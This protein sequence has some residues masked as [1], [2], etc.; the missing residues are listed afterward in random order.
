LVIVAEQCPPLP[1]PTLVKLVSEKMFHVLGYNA[2]GVGS[3]PR[4]VTSWMEKDENV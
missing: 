2:W 4:D 1:K 3:L